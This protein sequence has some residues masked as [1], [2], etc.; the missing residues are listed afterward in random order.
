MAKKNEAYIEFKAKTD[1]FQK[2]IK[3]MNSQLKTASNELRLNST[4]LK[5]AGESAKLLS[6]RQAIL[7]KELQASA[8]KVALTEQSLA[9]CKATLGENSKEYQSLSNAV[10]AA[11]NQQAA[12]QNELNATTQKLAALE[13]E[14]KRAVSSFGQLTDKIDKQ[15]SELDSL[16]KAYTEAALSKGK[17]SD[18]A[19]ALGK[20]IESLSGEL[21]KN[22]KE[23]DNAEN[24]ADKFDKTLGYL[25]DKVKDTSDGFTVAKGAISTFIGNGLT[26]LVD[27]AKDAASEIY[28]LAEETREF[29]QDLGTLETA[30]S[31]AGFSADVAKNTWRELYG[32]FGEDDKAVEAAN[33]I[34]RMAKNQNDLNNWVRI[35]TGIWGTYQDALPVEGLAE[36]AGETAKTGQVTGGLADALNWSSEAAK[37]FAGYMSKDVTTAEDAFNVALSKCTN[38]QE[39]QKLVTDTLTQ[40]YGKAADKYNETNKSVTE[41]NKATADYSLTQAK[42]GEKI[43]PVTTAVKN[44]FNGILEKIIELAGDGNFD[45][46]S[47]KVTESFDKAQESLEW[48]SGNLPSVTALFGGLTAAIVA[49]T[50]ATKLKKVADTAAA[51]GTTILKVAQQGLNAAFKANAIGIVLTGITLLVSAF[52]YL[53]NNCEGFRNFFINMWEKIKTA[54]SAVVEW[55]KTTA[56]KVVNFFKNNWKSI[57]LFIANP[58]AGAFKLLWD[59][60]EGFRNFFI[61]T[62]EKIKTAFSAVV[63]WFKGAIE[64]IAGFFTR[65]WEGVKTVFETIKNII[66][67]ALM[68]IVNIIKAAFDLITLPFRFI[69]ENCKEYVFA[70]F[71][72]IKE[73]ISTAI[74]K[75]KEIVQIGFNFIKEK[76]INPIKEAISAAVEKFEAFKAAVAEI[77]EKIKEKISA[78]FTAAKE[79]ILTPIIEAK[80]KAVETFNAIKEKVSDKINQLKEKVTNGFNT[81]KEKISAPIQAAKNKVNEVFT[82]IKDF[83]VSK[84]EAIKSKVTTVFNA[85]KTAI[86]TPINKAKETVKKGI[87]AIKGFFDKLKIKFPNIKL[88]HFSIDG[89]FSLS[90][91]SVP[92]LKIDWYAKG[93]AFTAPTIVPTLSGLKGFGEAG[94]EYALPLN[95]RSLTPLANL[96]NKLQFSGGSADYIANRVDSAID[97]LANRLSRLEAA[98]YVDGERLA[99]ATAVYDDNISGERAQLEDRGLAV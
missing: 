94:R 98:F 77:I 99:T 30:F 54:F 27:K 91:P 52:I 82:A 96:L 60:C 68:F 53:W 41:A 36:A 45:D 28:H 65:L 33:N 7:Q 37:M 40:L 47:S 55:I 57:L 11:K 93:A 75:V 86:E 9:E 34:A 63:E 97:R 78:V 92:K 25:K 80:D 76:I 3:D 13:S 72:K 21:L 69:W 71:E 81:V 79:K 83:I 4:E 23:I 51:A 61:E 1:G 56:G 2:G 74:N 19:K 89:K 16:K 31:Q 95:E 64:S 43:E 18:E 39:R 66:T 14:N 73:V 70:A 5:G 44:G 12:I 67:V 22:K 32:I 49:Q 59:N 85:V 10:L 8:Q 84:I 58:F 88:P 29:R 42:M 20:Q 46:F 87:D 15:E 50:A 48:F 35:T 17:D 62:W 6:D 26:A 38:E 24:S 90:P